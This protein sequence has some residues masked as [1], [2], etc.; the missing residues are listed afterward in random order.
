MANL[1]TAIRLIL[2]IPVTWGLAD[3]SI[4]PGQVL[5]LLIFVAVATDYLDGIVARA[6]QTAS[7]KGQ[8]FDHGTD[9][10]FVTSG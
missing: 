5:L 9:F 10:L 6:N 4:I 7:E 3:S 1:L 8:L 2:V